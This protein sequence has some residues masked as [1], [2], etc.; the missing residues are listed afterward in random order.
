MPAAVRKVAF[1]IDVSPLAGSEWGS[2]SDWITDLYYSVFRTLIYFSGAEL[3]DQK[4]E[5]LYR[6]YDSREIIGRTPNELS[7]SILTQKQCPFETVDSESLGGFRSALIL[8]QRSLEAD[9]THKHALEQARRILSN[10]SHRLLSGKKRA[11]IQEMLLR[12]VSVLL[13]FLTL[14]NSHF[15]K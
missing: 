11:C 6:F 14:P 9:P 15:Q 2:V 7:R 4:L 13:Y 5:W 3:L 1:L 8:L 10:P 12:Y